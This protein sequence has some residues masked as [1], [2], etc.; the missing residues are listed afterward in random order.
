VDRKRRARMRRRAAL[1]IPK[2]AW[3]MGMEELEGMEELFAVREEGGE[4]LEEEAAGQEEEVLLAVERRLDRIERRLEG[5]ED[6]IDGL[7]RDVGRLMAI[8]ARFIRYLDGLAEHVEF[9]KLRVYFSSP[10]RRRL[11]V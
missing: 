2:W 9:P 8:M 1:S 10:K 7:S 4:V 3:E 6:D 5:L 11:V